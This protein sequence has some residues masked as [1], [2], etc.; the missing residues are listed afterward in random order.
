MAIL[1]HHI[2]QSSIAQVCVCVCVYVYVYVYVCVYM[3][4]HCWYHCG[5]VGEVSYSLYV[6]LCAYIHVNVYNIYI[7]TYII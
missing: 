3:C 2:K 7:Y 5:V 4:K 6:R 1:S